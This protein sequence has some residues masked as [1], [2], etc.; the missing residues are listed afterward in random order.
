MRAVMQNDANRQRIRSPRRE[1]R[2]RS[3]RRRF[4]ELTAQ[5]SDFFHGAQN[6]RGVMRENASRSSAA[7][8]AV[9]PR[10]VRDWPALSVKSMQKSTS[11]SVIA[12]YRGVLSF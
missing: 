6:M 9:Y 2:T 3:W 8:R 10:F 4:S 5:E 12:F 1:V 7:E 11:A